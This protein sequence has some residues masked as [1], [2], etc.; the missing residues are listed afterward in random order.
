MYFDTFFWA[1]LQIH[2]VGLS[3]IYIKSYV[4]SA[5]LWMAATLMVLSDLDSLLMDSF[6]SGQ[7]CLKGLNYMVEHVWY[8]GN[9]LS[10]CIDCVI[11]QYFNLYNYCQDEFLVLIVQI[12]VLTHD[13][14]TRSSYYLIVRI[15]YKVLLLNC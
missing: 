12:N 7:V 3:I 6:P 2:K 8:T 1:Y 10:S 15:K 4:D 14:L 11:S 5:C 9:P 13:H